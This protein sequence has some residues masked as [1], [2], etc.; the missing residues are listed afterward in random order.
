MERSEGSQNSER[1]LKGPQGPVK[2]EQRPLEEEHQVL[3]EAKL[4]LTVASEN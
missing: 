3:E 4:H 1:H 2:E